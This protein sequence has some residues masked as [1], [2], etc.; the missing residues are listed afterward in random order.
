MNYVAGRSEATM[1]NIDSDVE[2]PMDTV[3]QAIR[4]LVNYLESV[5]LVYCLLQTFRDVTKD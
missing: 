2:I 3:Q 4:K 1:N 5:V